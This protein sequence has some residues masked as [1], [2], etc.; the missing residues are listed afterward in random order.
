[1]INESNINKDLWKNIKVHYAKE[2]YT[3]AI[4]DACL[5]IIQLI[6]EKS[7]NEDLDGEKLINHVFSE[8]SPK[9]L[10]NP[11]Q[12]P[13]EKDEQRGFGMIL[14]GIICAI[15]NPISHK[16]DFKYEKEEA[17]SIL[18]FLNN[19]ILPKLD[20]SKDFGY[21]EDWFSFIFEQNNNDSQRYS[22]VILENIP[23]KEKLNLLITIIE[24]LS[25]VKQEKYYYFINEL[26]NSLTIKE[27]E[28]VVILLN[29]K[30]IK[31][32][33]DQYLRMFFNHFNPDI[34]K[35]LDKLVT[36]R[37]EEMVFSSLEIGCSYI[38]PF[39]GE[40]YFKD[41]LATWA[42]NWINMFNNREDIVKM[43]FQKLEN[44]SE[45][46]YVFKYFVDIVIDNDNI[47][48]FE[49][50]IVNNL[51]LGN[52][53]FRRLLCGAKLMYD[54]KDDIF[55]K[56]ELWLSYFNDTNTLQHNSN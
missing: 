38:D 25:F 29:Q 10:I 20:D 19:Y 49:K 36:T 4:K 41:D 26:L 31:V 54:E 9:L 5:Y 14:R 53:N 6:Q 18:L 8:K 16:N 43:L 37:I 32:N 15:R 40:K 13:T 51:K 17:D 3:D 33:D 55:K 50:T 27:K 34:W 42:L 30:L 52:D 2:C 48:K 44:D 21:V 11:N 28:S 47:M 23:K 1:M 39:N 22:N 56:Y 46:D 7:E 45:A 24:K 35:K 12:T